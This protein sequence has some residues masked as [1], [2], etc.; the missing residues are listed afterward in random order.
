M[1]IYEIIKTVG[2]PIAMLIFFVI[3]DQ[4]RDKGDANEKKVLTEEIKEVR[5]YQINKLEGLV[6]DTKE[7]VMKSTEASNQQTQVT[8]AFHNELKTRPCLKDEYINH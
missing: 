7:A 6:L 8:L 5:D 4:K 1:D 2:V 3:K